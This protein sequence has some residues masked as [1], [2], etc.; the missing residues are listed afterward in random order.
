MRKS[1]Y[2]EVARPRRA[3]PNLGLRQ[4]WRRDKGVASF[5]NV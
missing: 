2:A 4:A 3:A 5:R 1:D